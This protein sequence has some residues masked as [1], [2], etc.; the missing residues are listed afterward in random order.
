MAKK[1]DKNIIDITKRDKII[2]IAYFI[3]ILVILSPT[4]T[5]AYDAETIYQDTEIYSDIEPYEVEER[6]NTK[7]A[8]TAEET[9]EDS[10]PVSR[11]V[12]YTEQQYY[13]EKLNQENCDKTA[14]CFCQ[15]YA[16]VEGSVKCVTCACQKIRSVTKYRKEVSYETITKTRP[17]LNYRDVVKARNVTKFNEVNK[18][19]TI[20]KVKTEQRTKNANWLFGFVV[21][22]KLEIG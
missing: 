13:Y 12:P 2:L 16:N 14:D 8:Y 1:E 4:K 22:W 15:G 9:Y 18:T 19:R 17:V 7:E 11:D 5:V 20:A 10:V 6:Y 3:G 21:P